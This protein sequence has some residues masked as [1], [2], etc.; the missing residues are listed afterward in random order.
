MKFYNETT[1]YNAWTEVT[2]DFLSKEEN[3]KEVENILNKM[4]SFETGE[5]SKYW[6]TGYNRLVEL[7][8]TEIVKSIDE[9]Y[10]M[11]FGG[12]RE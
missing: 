5:S 7:G 6:E 8:E 9:K 12:V 11:M 1:M 2:M 3:R 10:Y 4:F